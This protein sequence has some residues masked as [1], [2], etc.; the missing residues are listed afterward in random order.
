MKTVAGI[1][2][3]DG[4]KRDPRLLLTTRVIKQDRRRLR[5]W[6]RLFPRWYHTPRTRWQIR[7]GGTVG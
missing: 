6:L 4:V 7:Y 5:R 3:D 2:T 1:N